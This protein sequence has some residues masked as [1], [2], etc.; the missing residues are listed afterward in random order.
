MDCS[1]NG[2]CAK[3]GDACVCDAG[4][5]G[6]RCDLLD[7]KITPDT[8]GYRNE[9]F[10]SWG[11]NI[12]YEDGKYHLFVAQFVNEC[13]LGL[14]G[15]ASSIVRTQSDSYLGPFEY[16]ETVVSA[17]S[18]NPTIRKSPYDGKF[19]LFMIGAG[20]SEDPP[21]CREDSVALG[22]VLEE[23]SIHVSRADSVHGPWS[24]PKAVT[25]SNTSTYLCNGW[26]N[27]SP[28]FMPDG[29][30]YLAFQAG[31]CGD[32]HHDTGGMV[33]LAYATAWDQPFA[34]TSPDP[35]TPKNW[36]PIHPVCWA[37]VDEDPFLWLDS[38]GFHILTHGICPSGL[39]QAHYK[40]SED[41]ITWRTSMLQT[42][43]YEV[44]YEG[45][46]RHF[47]A[48][49]ERP[50]IV[51]KEYDE[52]TGLAGEPVALVNG[53]CGLGVGKNRSDY[54]CVFDQLTGMTWTLVRPLGE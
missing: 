40:F 42:Y 43:H 46:G 41:G 39:R 12:I 7:V 34:L 35:V 33:G 18:H 1:L 48:R 38:R 11:G 10:A 51:F 21:D 53:V 2:D 26:T 36:D 28:H 19:Y 47:F 22:E 44:A 5:K 37:G 6:K 4:W 14:W 16:Q 23:S 45:G 8:A 9:S 50:Q 15:L 32:P 17:F 29:S 24:K 3:E 25:F 49:M 20:D 31:S 54:E 13:P 52:N 30:V 27:P